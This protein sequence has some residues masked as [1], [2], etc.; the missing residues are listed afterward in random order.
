MA[1]VIV[2]IGPAMQ[3]TSEGYAPVYAGRGHQVEEVT[4]SGTAASTTISVS[5][6]QDIATVDNNGPEDVWVRFDGTA[7]VENGHFV[8]AYTTKD[9]GRLQ[10]GDVASVI[11]DS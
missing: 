2:S 8:R 3:G 11:N 10:P 5:T 4:S 6:P 7:A 9:F 1:Q